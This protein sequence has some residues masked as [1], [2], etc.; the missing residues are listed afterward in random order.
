[1]SSFLVLCTVHGSTRKEKPGWA[2]LAINDTFARSKELRIRHKSTR[3]NDG[4]HE[5]DQKDGGVKRIAV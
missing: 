4:Q 3:K 5:P 2:Y 1:M